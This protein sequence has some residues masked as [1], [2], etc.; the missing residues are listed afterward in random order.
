VPHF[1]PSIETILEG[2]DENDVFLTD[3][4][5]KLISGGKIYSKVPLIIGINKFEGIFSQTAGIKKFQNM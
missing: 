1:A 2:Q 3:T 4:L 5:F